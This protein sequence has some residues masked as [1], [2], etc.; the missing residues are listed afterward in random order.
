MIDFL[1]ASTVARAA[2]LA[3]IEFAWQG[4]LI[5]AATWVALTL[6]RHATAQARYGVACVGLALLCAT[7]VGTGVWAFLNSPAVATANVGASP[8]SEAT[9]G[10]DAVP[11]SGSEAPAR[12]A[13]SGGWRTRARAWLEARLPWVLLVWATG[14]ILLA[15]HFA[16]GWLLLGRIRRAAE[17]VPPGLIVVT[18]ETMAQRLGIRRRV[19]FLISARVVVPAVV[20]W[21]KPAV[22]VPAGMFAGMPAAHLDAI[23]AHELAHIRRSDFLVNLLQ[24]AAELLLFYHPAVWWVSRQIRAERELCADDLAVT[25]SGNRV[26]YATALAS[27]ESIRTESLALAMGAGDDLLARIRRL[28]EPGAAPARRF[29]GGFAMTIVL[30]LLMFVLTGAP[31][32]GTSDGLGRPEIQ[33]TPVALRPDIAPTPQPELTPTAGQAATRQARALV[34]GQ[35]AAIAA[36]T[37]RGT[38]TGTVRDPDGGV[39]PGVTVMMTGTPTGAQSTPVGKRTVTNARGVFTFADI[40][41]GLYEF[42]ASIPGFKTHRF[43]RVQVRPDARESVLIR[44]EVGTVSEAV[45]VRSGATPPAVPSPAAPRQTAA[46]YFDLAKFYYQQGRLVEAE[47]VTNRALQMMRSEMPTA[48]VG[49]VSDATGPIRVG[50]DIIEP[51]KIRDVKP[52]YPAEAAAAGIVGVVIIEAT[53][54]TDGTV[55]NARILRGV[56]GLDDAALGAVNQWLYTPT[57]LNGQPIDVVMTVSVTFVR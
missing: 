25:V 23:L 10:I 48:T 38:L 32:G 27:L 19:T 57:K 2:G 50:G 17:P 24:C 43:S 5:G 16:G 54:G 40:E 13:S 18:A 20:G 9:S 41:P 21:I 28:V 49:P 14:V 7:P 1:A 46:D 8:G 45:T 51:K 3:L 34:R 56:P 12:I 15:V 39:I 53:I 6:L 11:S 55:R 31:A 52:I 30:L 26:T 33:G 22:L 35:V 42:T 29:S 47:E 37:G 36:Q 4:A 44:L